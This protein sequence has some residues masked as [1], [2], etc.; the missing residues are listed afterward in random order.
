MLTSV[1][2]WFSCFS[3]IVTADKF[4]LFIWPRCTGFGVDALHDYALSQHRFRGT[5]RSGS[6]EGDS[7]VPLGLNASGSLG[8][9]Y[10]FLIA[11][12]LEASIESADSMEARGYGLRGRSSFHLFRFAG[13]EKVL[14]A[15][16]LLLGGAV[17]A[18]CA[19]GSMSIYYYPAILL[20]RFTVLQW[21]SLAAYLGLM[22]IPWCWI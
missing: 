3:V 7:R 15:A 18:A 9:K 4:Y 14:L 11:W 2:I 19:A 20:P 17:V 16:I 13:G 6:W 12:S 10:P 1:I 22:S 5:Q 8:K 21:I